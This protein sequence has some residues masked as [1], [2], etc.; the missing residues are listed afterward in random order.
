MFVIVFQ[1]ELFHDR[2]LQGL[3]GG[4]AVGGRDGAGANVDKTVARGR[5]R[6]LGT[7]AQFYFLFLTP[8]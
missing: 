2:L 7:P 4:A 1:E 5:A 6:G 8:N 3:P